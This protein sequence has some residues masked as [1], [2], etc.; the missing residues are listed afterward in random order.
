MI[1][2]VT[3]VISAGSMTAGEGRHGFRKSLH[4]IGSDC[5]SKLGIFM[6]SVFG[7][8]SFQI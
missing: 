5:L 7:F 1:A 2:V 8:Y 6:F 3:I 4:E